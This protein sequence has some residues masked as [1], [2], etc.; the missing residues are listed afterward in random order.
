MLSHCFFSRWIICSEDLR[1]I[2]LDDNLIGE[3]GGLEILTALRQ[4]KEGIPFFV[5]PP[6]LLTAFHQPMVALGHI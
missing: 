6:F 1:E 4:R 3:L 2:D 5:Y